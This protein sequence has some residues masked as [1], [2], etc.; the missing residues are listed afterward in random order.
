ME[1]MYCI[2]FVNIAIKI[3]LINI[4]FAYIISKLIKI[5]LNQQ[6]SG[7]TVVLLK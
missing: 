5:K 3:Q 4:I 6:F 1:K 2:N 7:T